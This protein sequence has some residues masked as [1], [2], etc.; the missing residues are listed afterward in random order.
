MMKKILFVLSVLAVLGIFFSCA[1]SSGGG[2]TSSGPKLTSLSM[3]ESS[4]EAVLVPPEMPHF[5][6]L[7]KVPDASFRKCYRSYSCFRV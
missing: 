5:E 2:N 4:H 6:M 3:D 1:T 7:P